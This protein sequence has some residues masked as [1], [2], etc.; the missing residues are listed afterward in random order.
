MALPT[1]T[2]ERCGPG[3]E[4]SD[5]EPGDLLLAHR[6]R[7]MPALISLAERR[8]FRGPEAVFAHWSHCAVVVDSGGGLV[9]AEATGVVKSPLSK[10]RRNEYH[11]VRLGPAFPAADRDRTVAYATSQVGAAFGYLALL[12]AVAFLA[13]GRPVRLIRRDH[14]ICSGLVVRALQAGGLLTELDPVTALPADVAKAFD[15][16]P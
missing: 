9:E 1:T 16:R 13:T 12:G 15:V 2:V 7:A 10:Y 4:A 14:Q 3:E 11:V 8:R 6:H 5:L